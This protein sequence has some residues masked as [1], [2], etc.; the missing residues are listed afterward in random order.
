MTGSNGLN[1]ARIRTVLF[2]LDGTLLDA[3]PAILASHRHA[4]KTVAGVDIDEVGYDEGALLAMRIPEA[5]EYF[6]FPDLAEEG[7]IAYDD[8]YRDEAFALAGRYERVKEMLQAL[9]DAGYDWGLVTNKA[10]GRANKDLDGL[11]GAGDMEKMV[12][13]VGAEH[14][15]DRKPHPAPIL[16]G[17]E[18]G[19]A[20]ASTSA[21]VGDGP[22]DI[23]SAIASGVVPIAA[24]YGYYDREILDDAGAAVILD[25]PMSLLDYLGVKR[26]A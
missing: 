2:D 13:L 23:E 11:I 26:P 4:L 16:A 14:T 19:G 25:E 20:D 7:A 3:R 9:V 15:D 12:C 22:H 10:T 21:Y 5:F 24:G 17:L 8:F 6:G 1:P 18:A